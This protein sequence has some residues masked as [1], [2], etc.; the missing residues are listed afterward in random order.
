V[1]SFALLRKMG[2]V[3]L[4]EGETTAGFPAQFDEQGHVLPR[5]E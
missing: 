2:F 4:N 1:S 5:R 3:F